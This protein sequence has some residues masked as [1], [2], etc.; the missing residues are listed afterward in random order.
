MT[1]INNTDNNKHNTNNTNTTNDTIVH[2]RHE[3]Y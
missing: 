1:I 2:N 3:H